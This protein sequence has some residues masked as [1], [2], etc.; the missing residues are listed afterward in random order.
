MRRVKDPTGR[1]DWLAAK[2]LERLVQDRKDPMMS[3]LY[4]EVKAPLEHLLRANL[5]PR[6][7]TLRNL[8]KYIKDGNRMLQAAQEARQA[9]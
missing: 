1:V 2:L 7:K 8:G 9:R 4:R 6:N 5:G 3:A